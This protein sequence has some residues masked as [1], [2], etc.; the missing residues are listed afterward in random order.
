MKFGTERCPPSWKGGGWYCDYLFVNNILKRKSVMLH[1]RQSIQEWTKWHLWKAAFKKFEKQAIS[2][3]I[4]KG[5]LPQILLGPFLNTLPHL[6]IWLFNRKLQERKHKPKHKH[7]FK[8]M[9]EICWKVL[10]IKPLIKIHKNKIQF[11]RNI[12]SCILRNM[13]ITEF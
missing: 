9:L 8:Q 5:C 11:S 10:K 3:Q 2:L 1:L 13:N 4:F 6:C 12:T 7:L